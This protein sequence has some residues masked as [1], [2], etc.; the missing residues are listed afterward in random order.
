MG[1]FAFLFL[2]FGWIC[3]IGR[4]TTEKVEISQSTRVENKKKSNR[5]LIKA[6]L[7]D[8]EFE[9]STFDKFVNV[10][11]YQV[12]C[13]DYINNKMEE[14]FGP[15]A[16]RLFEHYS[17]DKWMLFCRIEMAKRGKVPMIDLNGHIQNSTVAGLFYPRPNRE[18]SIAFFKWYESL[19]RKNG[20]HLAALKNMDSGSIN[21]LG[22]WYFDGASTDPFAI[23]DR[24]KR[25]W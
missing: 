16:P 11:G 17:H 25:M 6:R 21:G 1:P 2:V 19:I 10:A 4:L 3:I 22:A 9:R 7:S 20:G 15:G 8:E 12:E 13:E 24:G 18:Q 5:D 23:D 14:L